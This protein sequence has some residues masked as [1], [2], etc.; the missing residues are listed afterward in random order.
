MLCSKTGCITAHAGSWKS[1]RS[2]Q[3]WLPTASSASFPSRQA[4]DYGRVE[5]L[6]RAASLS[7]IGC[8]LPHGERWL[9]LSPDREPL[10]RQSDPAIPKSPNGAQPT[11][12][13]RISPKLTTRNSSPRGLLTKSRT[14]SMTLFLTG[15]R[16]PIPSATWQL[17]YS[18][19][20]AFR[21]E[22]NTPFAS[23]PN[24]FHGR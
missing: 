17:P 10:T 23:L 8:L 22:Q 20:T 1:G 15:S 19:T 12:R 16:L 5:T 2:L 3:C 4:T 9:R 18:Q 7:L 13:S 21:T 11:I 6:L 24:A 14:N